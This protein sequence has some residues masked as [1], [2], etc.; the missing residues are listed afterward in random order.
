MK[1]IFAGLAVV[2][3]IATCPAQALADH[4]CSYPTGKQSPQ[5][6]ELVSHGIA[7]RSARKVISGVRALD[8]WRD[9]YEGDSWGYVSYATGGYDA[10]GYLN[11]REFRCEYM[12]RGI[13]SK[14]VIVSCRATKNS[15]VR[16]SAELHGQ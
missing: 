6:R 3:A 15:H 12:L 14:Y 4:Y 9:A 8:D 16:V 10:D 7:C 5:V 13:V 11:E 2:G 1:S